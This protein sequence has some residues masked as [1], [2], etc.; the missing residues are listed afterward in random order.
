MRRRLY[1]NEEMQGLKP[2]TYQDITKQTL[3]HAN[4]E[5]ANLV[6]SIEEDERGVATGMHLPVI[7]IDLPAHVEPST[8]PGHGHLY[9]DK[10]LTWREYITLLHVLAGLGIVEPGYV[11]V[12]EKRGATFVRRP[13]VKKEV[14]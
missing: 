8:T 5:N 12:A 14:F 6:S 7:D 13:G 1:R 2:G 4:E 3:Y 11:A 10:P 9:I